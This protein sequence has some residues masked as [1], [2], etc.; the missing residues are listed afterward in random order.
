M[1]WNDSFL[2]NERQ[3]TP[4]LGLRMTV[5][6]RKAR[7]GAIPKIEERIREDLDIRRGSLSASE[8]GF[9]CDVAHA[10]ARKIGGRRGLGENV[11]RVPMSEQNRRHAV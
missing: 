7:R 1:T 5:E 2:Y 9:T 10:G 8:I 4:L 11:S 3:W 6:R